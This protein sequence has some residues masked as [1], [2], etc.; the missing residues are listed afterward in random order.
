MQILCTH[1]GTTDGWGIVQ[2]EIISTFLPPCVKEQFL[3]SYVLDRFQ[4]PTE[5]LT[6]YVMSVLGA[7]N[8]LGFAGMEAQ[9]V[10]RTVQNLYPRVKSHCMFESQ[11]ESVRDLYSLANTVA[12]AVAVEEQGGVLRQRTNSSLQ[13]E[14]SPAK[15]DSRGLR[16][17][18]PFSK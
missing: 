11:P 15:T 8:I 1:V 16:S 9:L 6:A 14:V 12:E 5:D 7:A 13:A 3:A 18:R 10:Q 2:S 4:A 17:G